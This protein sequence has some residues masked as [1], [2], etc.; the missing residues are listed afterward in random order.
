MIKL[1]TL[2]HYTVH[3]SIFS[4]F[5]ETEIITLK[6]PHTDNFLV[7][8]LPPQSVNDVTP[9]S[10]NDNNNCSNNEPLVTPFTTQRLLSN[11]Y[12]HLLKTRF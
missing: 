7:R 1:S 8:G 4:V 6:N 11:V 2:Q 9:R 12:K 5:T 10:R 3:I